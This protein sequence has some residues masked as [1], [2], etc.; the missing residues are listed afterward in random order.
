MNELI[1]LENVS[2]SYPAARRGLFGS[3]RTKRALNQISFSLKAGERLALVGLN[4][5]GKSTLLRLLAGIYPPDEGTVAIKG[6]TAA[7]FNLGIGMR[8]D[9]SGRQNIMLQALVNGFSPSEAQSKVDDIIEFSGLADVIDDPI[10][11]YSQGMAVRLSFAVATSSNPDILLLDEW[12][13]AGDR[14]FRQKAEKR[15]TNMVAGS[16]GLV[17]ASH[18]AHIVRLYCDRA[19]WLHEGEVKLIGSVDEVVDQFEAETST[20][21]TPMVRP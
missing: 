20:T 14:V 7:L 2:L 12:I 4:G 6:R 17:L 16:R 11:T 5:S 9:L 1:R 15:L 19:L 18:N 3:V 21:D 8:V 13:G 10:N